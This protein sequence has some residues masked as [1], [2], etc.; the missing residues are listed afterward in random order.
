[1]RAATA[2]LPSLRISWSSVAVLPADLELHA[3]HRVGDEG[4][5]VRPDGHELALR[6]ALALE[7]ELAA[8]VG[9]VA[10]A[11][12]ADILRQRQRRR[13]GLQLRLQHLR[14][15]FEDLLVATGCVRRELPKRVDLRDFERVALARP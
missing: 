1:M 11:V 15:A 12:N 10:D 4:E 9:D 6:S 5:L 3:L 14:A 8:F 7:D 13:D 2:V